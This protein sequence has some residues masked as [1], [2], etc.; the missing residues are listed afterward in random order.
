MLA[1]AAVAAA[2]LADCPGQRLLQRPADPAVRGPWAVSHK[3][4][5]GITA[6][7]FSVDFFFP[8]QPGSEKGGT[9]WSYDLRDHVPPGIRRKLPDSLCTPDA[10]C[11]V[12]KDEDGFAGVWE[13]LPLDREHGPY[14]V[15][16]YVHGTAAWGAA[17]VKLEAHLAS[18]GFVVVG[19]D[20]PGIMLKDLL[21]VTELIIPP[22][23]DQPGDTRLMHGELLSMADPRLAWLKGH[24][25]ASNVG[26]MGHSAGGMAVARLGDIAKVV[27]PMAGGGPDNT[28]HGESAMVLGGET[29]GIISAQSC[30]RGYESYEHTPK[31]LLVLAAAGHQFCTDLCWI[32]KDHGGI[33][34]VAADNGVWQAPLMRSLADDGCNFRGITK[35]LSPE[36][37]WALSNFALAAV[38]EETLQCD[39][40]MT[41][42]LSSTSAKANV[43]DYQERLHAALNRT[44][45]ALRG[46]RA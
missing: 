11:P 42:V 15:V 8:A 32:A 20:Y 19:I 39:A 40:A 33:A 14:P 13:N 17:S 9:P 1:A 3:R 36:A 41:G 45:T 10:A 28:P 38:F 2:A 12:F 18:R 34:Q 29:D 44:R 21:G 22:P 43:F 7:N 27:V 35:F 24:I 30:I 16:F 37:G 4:V 25:D 26:V 6:R 5:E 46:A 23:T 31:R